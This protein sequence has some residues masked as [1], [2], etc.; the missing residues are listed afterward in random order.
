MAGAELWG[1]ILLRVSDTPPPRAEVMAWVP[2]EAVQ[3]GIG[4]L[5]GD[6]LGGLQ[7]WA[8]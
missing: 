2:G 4:A 6:N 7:G 8:E 5:S 3:G 1:L